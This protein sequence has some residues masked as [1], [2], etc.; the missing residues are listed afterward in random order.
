MNFMKRI[1]L[2]LLILFVGSSLDAQNNPVEEFEKKVE[3][4]IEKRI[5][6]EAKAKAEAA[7]L[8]TGLIIICEFIEVEAMEFSN[9]LLE[10][11]ITTDAT[12]L[13]MQAQEWVKS[14]S[15]K[16]A[17]TM[18]VHARSDS[19]RKPRRYMSGCMRP[20]T[21]HRKSLCARRRRREW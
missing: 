4:Q 7:P 10:N 19:G 17:E 11:P 21:I 13:R 2:P 6:K 14:G 18:V 20:N 9:W 15:G 8:P 16:I 1:F 5:V 3:Q 12:P